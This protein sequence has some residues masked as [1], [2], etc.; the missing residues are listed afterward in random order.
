VSN[1]LVMGTCSA[2]LSQQWES[3]LRDVVIRHHDPRSK[4]D[5]VLVASE[6]PQLAFRLDVGFCTVEP[7][8]ESRPFNISTVELSYFPGVALARAW[9]AAAWACY[10]M[11][12]A[13]ELVSVDGVRPI[14]PHSDPALDV[15]LRDGLPAVLTPETLQRAL[16]LVMRPAAVLEMTR[17]A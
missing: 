16:G 10:M 2:P 17:A 6:R 4:V 12:E 7:T 5:L 11:H 8:K 14:D 3:A 15:C 1:L 13:L 9:V